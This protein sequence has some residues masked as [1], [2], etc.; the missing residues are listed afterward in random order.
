MKTL[1]SKKIQ[2][3]VQSTRVLIVDDDY[4]MRKV[5]RSLLQA[6]GIRTYYD[7]ADGVTG[8]ESI[9]T[10]NP[11]VV[12]LDW[13]LP[14][15]NGAEFMRI[16]RSPLTFPVPA[17]PIIMLTANPERETVIEAVRLGVNEFIC[18]P[19]SAKTI[20]ERI[21]AIRVKPREMVRIGSYYGPAPRKAAA[22][23]DVIA[24]SN[25]PAWMS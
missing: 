7:A 2:E 12:I 18:K 15:I 11:D 4:Y 17:V 13:D 24:D 21:V 5:I 1:R 22:G 20:F 23:L 3:L 25:E 9:I 6:N 10:L 14:D 19:V 8:L 16:V